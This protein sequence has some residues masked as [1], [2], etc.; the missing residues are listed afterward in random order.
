[1][2][3]KLILLLALVALVAAGCSFTIGN[4]PGVVGIDIDVPGFILLIQ[5]K[6]Y[7]PTL[8]GRPIGFEV[9]QPGD[10]VHVSFNGGWDQYGEPTGL[11]DPVRFTMIEVRV[12]CEEK[13]AEDT[14][15]WPS[16]T[17][18]VPHIDNDCVWFPCW[19]GKFRKIMQLPEAFLPIAGYPWDPCGSHVFKAMPS[20]TATIYGEAKASVLPIDFVVPVMDEP[21]QYQIVRPGT[22][23]T[24]GE[25]WIVD[26]ELRGVRI[27]YHV[28][29]P[30]EYVVRWE[31]DDGNGLEEWTIDVPV[32]VFYITG[33]WPV[34]IGP[35]GTC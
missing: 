29:E 12:Q 5:A 11:S 9:Q 18:P 14:I 6:L 26:D 1:M 10:L 20:Q 13:N 19:T 35:T 15:F 28:R 4:I 22:T 17:Q 30:G 32:D 2:R 8:N 3:T 27:P 23:P 24:E 16:A 25:P 33:E 31:A 21:G 34:N 7:A